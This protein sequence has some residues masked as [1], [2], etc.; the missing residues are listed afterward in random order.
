[1]AANPTSVSTTNNGVANATAAAIA[2]K[3]RTATIS[4]STIGASETG[5]ENYEVVCISPAFSLPS[6][7]LLYFYD[8]IMLSC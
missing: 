3:Q 4:T 6:I 2:A 8:S 7:L 1:M 5:L